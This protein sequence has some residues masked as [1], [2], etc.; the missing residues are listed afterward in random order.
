MMNFHDKHFE[1]IVHKKFVQ[2]KAPLKGLFFMLPLAGV[3]PDRAWA[4]G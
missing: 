4:A 3:A 2:R 1:R